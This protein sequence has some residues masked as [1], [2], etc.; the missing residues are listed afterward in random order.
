MMT[1]L[2][3]GVTDEE[4]PPIVVVKE[5]TQ[6]KNTITTIDTVIK[7]Q[8]PCAINQTKSYM[9]YK[10]VTRR[11]SKQYKYIEKYMTARDGLLYAPDGSIGVALGSWWGDIGDKWTIELTNGQVFDVVKI[12]EKA[13]EHVIN[14]C[15]HK[16]DGSVIEFVVDGE[17]T[18]KSHYG[19][20][21]LIWNGNF[22]NYD[23]FKGQIKRVGKKHTTTKEVDI[24]GFFP[25]KIEYMS[26]RKDRLNIGLFINAW[27]KCGLFCNLFLQ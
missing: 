6:T 10:A 15:Q 19:S 9:D 2:F 8:S 1:M 13:D 18:P 22:N 7:W 24:S 20:N 5:E 14:G 11:N 23:K 4:P 12:D 17:T 25:K 21:G 16:T 27:V 26:K 3:S